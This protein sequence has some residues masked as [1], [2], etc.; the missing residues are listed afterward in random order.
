MAWTFVYD[1]DGLLNQTLDRIGL[2][3]LTRAWIGDFTWAY[4]AVGIVGSWVGTGLCMVLFIA[5]I[6]K[7]DAG[8]YEAIRLDGGGVIREFFTI[9]L[10]QL[11]G[12]IA[13]ALTLTVISALASFDVVFIMTQ[14]GPGTS[15]TVPGVTIYRLAFNY[16]QVGL[17]AALGIVLS[18]LVYVLV[19]GIN[20]LFRDKDSA[21]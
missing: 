1:Q 9:T 13:V 2:H 4:P 19:L 12:E 10:R 21:R 5:G 17:A 8:L 3:G 20:L 18:L 6:Q 14:G 16:N 11:R 15:T 7:I